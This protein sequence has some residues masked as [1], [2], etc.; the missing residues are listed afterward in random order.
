MTHRVYDHSYRDIFAHP[1]VVR[2][3]IKDFVRADWVR[4]IKTDRVG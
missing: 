2:D 3:L 4:Q 1:E